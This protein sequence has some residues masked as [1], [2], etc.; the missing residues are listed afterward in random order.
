MEASICGNG[1]IRIVTNLGP[2]VARSLAV[3]E[4]NGGDVSIYWI[5]TPREDGT[6]E[7]WFKP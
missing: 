3:F 4:N 7:Y 5:S 1:V 2:R 6:K